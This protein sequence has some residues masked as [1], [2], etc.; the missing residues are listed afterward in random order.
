M[1]DNHLTYTLLSPTGKASKV[2]SEST[3]RKAY[4]IHKRCFSGSIDTDVVIVDECGMVSLDVFCMLLSAI[5]MIMQ[6]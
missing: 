2:L 1:E 6:E 4:T 5:Q 3:G